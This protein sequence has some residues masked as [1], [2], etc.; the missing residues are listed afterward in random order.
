MSCVICF[1]ASSKAPAPAN[2]LTPP[3]SHSLTLNSPTPSLTHSLNDLYR[4]NRIC[5]SAADFAAHEGAGGFADGAGA[6]DGGVAAVHHE[7]AAAGRQLF[8]PDGGETGER[9]EDGFLPGAK[10]DGGT[11]G[12]GAGRFVT[13]LLPINGII[14][15]CYEAR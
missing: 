2:S 9:P 8:V 1:K 7:G 10:A 11:A 15:G 5:V 6:A 13:N 4:Q 12:G 14:L 3:F